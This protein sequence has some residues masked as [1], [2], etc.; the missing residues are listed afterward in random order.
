MRLPLADD[1][2]NAD[3][4]ARVAPDLVVL[5]ADAGLGTINA[6]RLCL[7]ALAGHATVVLLNRFDPLQPLHRAN[8]AWLTER[9]RFRVVTSVAELLDRL[10]L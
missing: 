10:P 5:V 3:L 4:C 9:D 7:T 8:R 1:G 6:V 2:D